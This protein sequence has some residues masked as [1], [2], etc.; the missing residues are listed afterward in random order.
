MA[1]A[2]GRLWEHSVERGGWW[3]SQ[4]LEGLGVPSAVVPLLGAT[5]TDRSHSDL[6]VPHGPSGSLHPSE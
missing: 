6:R 1:P 2:R 3:V 4:A 5:S